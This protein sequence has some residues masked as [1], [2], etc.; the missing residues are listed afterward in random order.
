MSANRNGNLSRT[1][2]VAGLLTTWITKREVY[3][4]TLRH[5][6]PFLSAPYYLVGYYTFHFGAVYLFGYVQIVK[7]SVT[8]LF[9]ALRARSLQLERG[10]S[11]LVPDLGYKAVHKSLPS[12]NHPRRRV[13]LAVWGRE[14]SW[15]NII[16]EPN[17]P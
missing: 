15:K 6:L 17:F 2:V 14:L 1:Y 11:R 9:A 12:Q 8:K 3:Y 4:T 16:V 7:F 5:S 10:G 13:G